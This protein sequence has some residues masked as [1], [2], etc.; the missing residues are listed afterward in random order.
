MLGSLVPGPRA[1]IAR[2]ISQVLQDLYQVDDGKAVDVK[3]VFQKR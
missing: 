2:K 1:E 3:A